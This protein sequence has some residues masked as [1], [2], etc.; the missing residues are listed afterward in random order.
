MTV[1]IVTAAAALLL[2]VGLLSRRRAAA[3]LLVVLACLGLGL[4]GYAV[5]GHPG[6]P[7]RPAPK[8]PNDPRWTPE[9]ETAQKQL[10]E[11]YGD[12]RAWLVL[13]DALIRMGRTSDAVEG[14]Q[15]ATRAIPNSPDLWVGMG[16]ALVVHSDGFVTP[17]AR[18]AF[19]KASRLNPRHPAPSYF[20]GL[21]WLQAGKPAEALEV[22]TALRKASPDSAPWVADLDRKIAAARMMQLMG[23]GQ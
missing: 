9:A 10:L 18:L 14:L 23:V 16:N 13:S 12:V 20:L 22:W 21:A 8:A 3:P 19:D 11:N 4:G 17:A 5:A 7:A 6:E 1:W 2:A 15:V